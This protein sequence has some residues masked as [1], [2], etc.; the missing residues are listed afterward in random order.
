MQKLTKKFHKIDFAEDIDQRDGIKWYVHIAEKLH[1]HFTAKTTRRW[2][3][4]KRS[5]STGNP[6]SSIKLEPAIKID[7]SEATISRK[8]LVSTIEHAYTLEKP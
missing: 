3:I 6:T 7:F 4:T 1:L 8:L 2:Q 5:Q